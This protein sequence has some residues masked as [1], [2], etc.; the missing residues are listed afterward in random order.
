MP[1]SIYVLFV[2]KYP[3]HNQ[4][5]VGDTV[6]ARL[7]AFNYDERVFEIVEIEES[8]EDGEPV[9]LY[10]GRYVGRPQVNKE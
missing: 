1:R 6:K 10:H 2:S 9:Y 4:I 3:D 5:G 7:K 8:E